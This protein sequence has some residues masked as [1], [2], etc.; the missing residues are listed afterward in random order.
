MTNQICSVKATPVDGSMRARYMNPV[1]RESTRRREHRTSSRFSR[2]RVS[3]RL[4]SDV[5]CSHHIN[6]ISQRVRT[7]C[8]CV[9]VSVGRH[10]FQREPFRWAA[11]P[12]SL[13]WFFSRKVFN[14]CIAEKKRTKGNG[15]R[16]LFL[17]TRF[18]KRGC[19]AKGKKKRYIELAL[20]AVRV[21][22]LLPI[23]RTIVCIAQRPTTTTTFSFTSKCQNVSV[24]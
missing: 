5:W 19:Y 3:S 22:Y 2:S 14:S 20:A 17:R 10:R 15:T 7:V 9:R 8:A 13:R 18:P 21:L 12:P 6:A 11:A 23:S 4:V 1:Q 24:V 16:T